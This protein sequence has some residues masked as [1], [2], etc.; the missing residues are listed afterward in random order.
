MIKKYT[1][2]LILFFWQMNVL[3]AQIYTQPVLEFREACELLGKNWPI[4]NKE[5]FQR[6][7]TDL[8]RKIVGSG[9]YP[10]LQVSARMSYQSDVT[11]VPFSA[12]GAEPP[13][14]SKDHYN[15]SLQISQQLF[16]GGRVSA[17][18]QM[19]QH[20]GQAEHARI[21]M[22]L[23]GVRS[24]MEQAWFGILLLQKEYKTIELLRDDFREQ[25]GWIRSLVENGVLL[26]GDELVLRAELIRAEQELTRVNGR[27]KAGYSVLSELLGIEIPSEVKLEILDDIHPAQYAR[28]NI[29][30]PEY[31][32]YDAGSGVLD[33]QIRA[34]GSDM[35]PSLSIF[36]TS[37]YGRPGLNVFDDDLQFY[38]MLGLRAQWS[39]RNTRNAQ[40]KSE[41]LNL[42]KNNLDADREAFTR[43]LLASLRSLEEEMIAIRSMIDQDQEVVRLRSLVAEEKKN[44]LMQGAITSTEYINELNAENRARLHLETRK[45]RLAQIITEYETKRGNR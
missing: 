24:R 42:Q 20:A 29:I 45:I 41:V 16:D 14:F 9:W 5:Q 34:A 36:A 12:P 11:E 10:E 15:V 28:E 21:E 8:N 3:H 7:I 23:F 35:L 6:Q 39:F 30:R 13:V 32:L 19:E 27:I 2:A 22:E 18:Q 33:S 44:L 31:D 38:W 26:P 25:I 40:L 37:A 17:I 43:N 1:I 4:A